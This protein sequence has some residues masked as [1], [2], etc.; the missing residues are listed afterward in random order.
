MFEQ[1]EL[2]RENISG[3]PLPDKRKR[4]LQA[5]IQARLLKL[6][7]DSADDATLAHMQ[8]F[9]IAVFNLRHDSNVE[10]LEAQAKREHVTDEPQTTN[11]SVATP[12]SSG[13]LVPDSN[14]PPVENQP[15]LLTTKSQEYGRIIFGNEPPSEEGFRTFLKKAAMTAYSSIGNKRSVVSAINHWKRE[16]VGD[17]YYE[18]RKVKAMV[19]SGGKGGLFALYI[20]PSKS[21]AYPYTG[22]D[23]PNGLDFR[24]KLRN[25]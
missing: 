17:F 23:F 13:P 24:K 12:E 7:L 22:T 8:R 9:G 18:D 19:I 15:Q 5:A 25:P 1:L 3:S 4:E 11:D 21:R 16:F 14:V 6:G 10:A 2:C 20:G